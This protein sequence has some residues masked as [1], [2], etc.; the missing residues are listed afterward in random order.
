MPTNIPSWFHISLI[1][2][3]LQFKKYCF[4]KC[5]YG[6]SFLPPIFP[7]KARVV[8]VKKVNHITPTPCPK[9]FNCHTEQNPNSLPWPRGPAW[10]C[11]AFPSPS[12]WPGSHQEEKC[13][14]TTPPYSI[15]TPYPFPVTTTP[16]PSISFVVLLTIGNHLVCLLMCCL[17]FAVE[18][19]LHQGFCASTRKW[20]EL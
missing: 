1:Y 17:S 6:P 10:F 14:L 19:K 7:E 2:L 9:P 5:S 13:S 16:P 8:L 3:D 18:Y 12:T 4:I 15:P 20:R 11:P